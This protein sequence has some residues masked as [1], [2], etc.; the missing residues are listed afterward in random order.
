MENVLET[1]APPYDPTCPA[2][3]M[4]E[5]TVQSVKETRPSIRGTKGR[6]QRVDYEYERNGTAS[7]F[8]FCEPHAKWRQVTARPRRTKAD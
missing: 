8:M 7:T 1:Y 3:C 6:A 2:V 4:D 5:Q